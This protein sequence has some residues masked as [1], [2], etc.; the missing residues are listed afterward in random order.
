MPVDAKGK[1]FVAAR[2]FHERKA[3]RH[4]LHHLLD[5]PLAGNGAHVQQ[6]YTRRERM[7]IERK[8]CDK[9][10]PDCGPSG[11]VLPPHAATVV[12]RMGGERRPPLR[13]GIRRMAETTKV[14]II[15]GGW[16]GGAHAKGYLAAGGFKVVAV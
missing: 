7:A 15:G 16:P 6:L 13:K 12:Q 9:T 3:G 11:G 14:G 5:K 4:D 2:H 10:D 8:K 1:G